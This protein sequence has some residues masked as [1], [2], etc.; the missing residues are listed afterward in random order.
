MTQDQHTTTALRG[1]AAET[2]W[3]DATAQANLVR[4]GE[5]SAAELLDA[6]I[7][8]I[9]VL[10]PTINAVVM[11]WFDH[12]RST[13]AAG[14]PAGPFTGVPFLLKDF[15]APYAGQTE[16][17]GNARL[18]ELA[19]TSPV[20]STL[21]AR[22]RAAGLVTAG[23]TNSPEFAALPTTEPIAW[24][25]TRNPWSLGHS[26]GG[27]S[28]G[29]AAAVA[30]GMVPIAQASDGSGSIRIPAALCGLVGLKPSRGRI[31]A[32]PFADES[33]PAV[34][35]G[36]SRTVRDT[37]ALLDAVHGPGVGDLVVAA[38]P[39]RPYVDELAADPRPLRIGVLDRAPSGVT[40]H[41]E[42]VAAVDGTA[43]LLESLGHHVE[44]SYPPAL[45]ETDI[46]DRSPVGIAATSAMLYSLAGLARAL[47]RELTPAD[48]EPLNWVRYLRLR[49][50]RA[51]ELLQAQGAATQFRRRV[52]Q[53]WA[54]GFD[55]LLTPTTAAPAA[56]L[57]TFD[58]ESE[59]AAGPL[60]NP[61]IAFTRAF[62]VTGQPAISLPAGRSTHGVP[63]GVQL[64]ADHGREDV[65]LAV[66]AQVERARPWS[67]EIP[68]V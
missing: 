31:S 45:V 44:R 37:A 62:N 33:G 14:L 30:A 40:V 34:F 8:R 52:L 67:D 10:N 13:V 68:P 26:T 54:D 35:L 51:A 23:R 43:R 3:M 27:S 55:L 50:M 7:E 18:K 21:V 24:G 1:L 32:G 36:V 12:A 22:L 63:I 2:R 46:D 61:Y 66:G 65:L 49:E 15:V 53:W 56:P 64:A 59:E 41:P 58:G 20:D 39:T 57:G 9:T 47:G 6:A 29:A 16:S 19:I 42:L 48:M 4:S 25:P 60:G 5:V 17:N 11:E 38:P 28:G